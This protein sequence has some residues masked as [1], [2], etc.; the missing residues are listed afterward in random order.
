LGSPRRKARQ[1]T[2]AAYERAMASENNEDA[3]YE[4]ACAAYRHLHPRLT[5]AVVRRVVAV[6]VGRALSWSGAGAVA[7]RRTKR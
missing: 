3:A 5:E 1:A 4:A 2:I 7:S 6:I